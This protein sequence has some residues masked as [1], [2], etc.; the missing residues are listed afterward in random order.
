DSGEFVL[1]HI[2]PGTFCLSTNSCNEPPMPAIGTATIGKGDG[3][4]NVELAAP[5]R[6]GAIGGTVSFA[7]ERGPNVLE[8]QN[9]WARPIDSKQGFVGDFWGQIDDE[10]NYQLL[11]MPPGRYKVQIGGSTG[12]LIPGV[13]IS[14]VRVRAGFERALNIDVP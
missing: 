1:R 4:V 10:G 6:S 12:Q 14:D 7:V 11:G 9:V 13:W 2:P 8:G 3:V 5:K